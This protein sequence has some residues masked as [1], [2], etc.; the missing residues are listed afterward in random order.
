MKKKESTGIES[1]RA[2]L[3]EAA[4]PRTVAPTLEDYSRAVERTEGGE[5]RQFITFSLDGEEYAFD[6]ASALE[7]LKPGKITDVPLVEPYIKGII[8]VRG[9]MVMIV[10]L[11]KRLSAGEG[12]GGARAAKAATG[13]P[14]GGAA[15]RF[16]IAGSDE[17]KAAFLVDRLSGVREYRMDSFE[18]KREGPF[19]R[20]F[21]KADGARIKVLDIDNLLSPDGAGGHRT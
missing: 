14:N 11:K 16:V 4:G 12:G 20:G 9:E 10:D 5:T 17:S 13:G 1:G 15:S 2:S 21:I 7:V 19:V 6:A 3:D 18:E 8:S